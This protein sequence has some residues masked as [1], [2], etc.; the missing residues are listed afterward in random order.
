MVDVDINQ[1]VKRDENFSKRANE[2]YMAAIAGG[3]I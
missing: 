3:E 1:M 2:A